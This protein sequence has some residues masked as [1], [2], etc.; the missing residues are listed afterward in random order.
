[1]PTVGPET[2]LEVLEGLQGRQGLAVAH[3]GDKDTDSRG[4]REFLNLFIYYFYF[5]HFL[6]YI[7]YFFIFIL[8]FALGV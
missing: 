7:F 8:F 2:Y 6:K 1:M 5:L 4:P 3:C